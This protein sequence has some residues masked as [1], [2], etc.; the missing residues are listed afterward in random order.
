MS[1]TLAYSSDEKKLKEEIKKGYTVEKL[2]EMLGSMR[3]EY[4]LKEVRQTDSENTPMNKP[5]LI[6]QVVKGLKLLAKKKV[7]FKCESPKKEKAKKA[8][9]TKQ[10]KD[11]LDRKQEFFAG[12]GMTRYDMFNH[13]SSEDDAPTVVKYGEIFEKL[14]SEK[15]AKGMLTTPAGALAYGLLFVRGA[16]DLKDKVDVKDLDVLYGGPL[17]KKLREE[18]VSCV[19]KLVDEKGGDSFFKKT[20]C[21]LSKLL[22]KHKVDNEDVLKYVRDCEAHSHLTAL[23]DSKD[24]NEYESDEESDEESDAE[25]S[26]ADSDDSDADSDAEGSDDD[27]DKDSKDDKKGKDDKKDDKKGKDDKKD[28]KKGKGSKNKGKDDKGSKN[29]GKGSKGSDAD[30]VD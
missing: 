1:Y 23:P 3:K 25:E 14:Y 6:K 30:D 2:R 13:K 10:D 20:K 28:D 24:E 17:S 29:K 22:K 26:D 11:M 19:A 12:L 4:K 16:K 7:D 27:D 18:A 5:D 8:K 21:P 9:K 15:D